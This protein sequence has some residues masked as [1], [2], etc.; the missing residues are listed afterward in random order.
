MKGMARMTAMGTIRNTSA[1]VLVSCFRSRLRR[2][3]GQG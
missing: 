2:H 3:S 1:V